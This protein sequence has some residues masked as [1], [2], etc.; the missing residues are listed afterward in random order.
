VILFASSIYL[1]FV[2][3]LHS[4]TKLA[5]SGYA[6]SDLLINY[7]AGFIRRGL[8]GAWIR[9]LSGGGSSLPAADRILFVN[10][11]LL[12]SLLT[13]LALRAGRHRVWTTALVLA[14]PGGVFSMTAAHEFF[15]RKEIFFCT[16]LALS[17]FAVSVLPEITHQG[18]RRFAAFCIVA[19][20]FSVSAVLSLV[21]ESFLFLSAPANLFV[22]IAAARAVN[23]HSVSVLH[24]RSFEKGLA[25][26]Y[27]SFVALLFLCMGYFH[28]SEKSSNAIWNGLSPADRLMIG[29]IG[30]SAIGWTS[31]SLVQLVGEP[32]AV[33]ISGMAWFWL[34]PAGGM[35]LYCLALVALNLNPATGSD[36]GGQEFYRWVQCY[37]TLAACAVPIFL[38][39]R[40][41]G[42]WIASFNLSFLILW[43]S[44]PSRNLAT[45]SLG[46]WKQKAVVS[47]FRDRIERL[48]QAYVKMVRQHNSATAVTMFLFAIT[49][50]YPE[51][52]L[53]PSDPR[54]I[55]Y[56]GVHTIWRAVHG[57]PMLHH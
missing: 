44:I 4:V 16:A 27:G 21:H 50:R 23:P 51:S 52:I 25:R 31:H 9:M 37:L 55:L 53:E 48:S 30:K 13:I 40:D 46:R 47:G 43:L 39:G 7:D 41:W 8:M 57:H 19:F 20:V 15:Y 5:W 18:A 35:M 42:R 2:S 10:F 54:Y 29:S 26:I 28:G 14:I 3:T 17:A 6:F 1:V 34:V 38:L 45:F 24:E 49:F 33:M 56:M 11:V 36:A 22:V 32:V 12:V